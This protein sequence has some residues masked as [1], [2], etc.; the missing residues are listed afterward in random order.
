MKR[1]GWWNLASLSAVGSALAAA[2]LRAEEGPKDALVG[3]GPQ[4]NVVFLVDGEAQPPPPQED[5]VIELK[6]PQGD[7][8]LRIE[9]LGGVTPEAPLGKYWIGVMCEP[10]SDALRAQLNIDAGQGLIV[11]NVVP[12]SPA[13]A[14]GLKKY[15]VIVAAGDAKVSDV[16]TL[17]QAIEANGAKE[18][19]LGIVRG[20]KP[21]K[22]SLTPA[23]RKPVEDPQAAPNQD[24]VYRL[25][26][27]FQGQGEGPVMRFFHPGVVSAPQAMPDNLNLKIEKHGNE[28]AKVHV[29]QDGKSWDVTEDKLDALPEE[30]RGH[31]GRLLGQGGMPLGIHLPHGDGE[32]QFDVRILPAPLPPDVRPPSPPLRARVRDLPQ[33]VQ[34]ASGDRL[35]QRLDQLNER[36]DRLQQMIER[37]QQEKAPPAP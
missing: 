35:D 19:P 11:G 1:Q 16:A 29:E 5:V 27:R 34:E 3:G 26:Q 14:A 6:N 23:E 32:K 8:A 7:G 20:G 15:D 33:K 13:A 24:R 18:L 9:P 36:L 37:M 12:E 25:L 28:P 4:A 22:I 30:L 31:V 17:M 10:L 21:E 2:P